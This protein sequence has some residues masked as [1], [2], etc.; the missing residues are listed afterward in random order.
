M[1]RMSKGRSGKRN[2]Q[3]QNYLSS[4]TEPDLSHKFIVDAH[5]EQYKRAGL[6]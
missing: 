3:G 6:S 4:R 2:E 5:I 1:L